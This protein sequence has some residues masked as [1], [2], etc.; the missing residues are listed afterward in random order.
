MNN[1]NFVNLDFKFIFNNVK[2]KELTNTKIGLVEGGAGLILCFSYLYKYTNNDSYLNDLL[3]LLDSIDMIEN[4]INDFSLGTGLTGLAW[5]I[6]KIGNDYIEN[7]S[8]WLLEIQPSLE[9]EY[10]R[11]IYLGNIDYFGGALGL[12]FYF[13]TTKTITSDSLS[14]CIEL[15]VSYV[16][17]L[18]DNTSVQNFDSKN[19]VNRH[20]AIINLGVP[21]GITG[22]L[23]FLLL[24]K[25]K[26][27]LKGQDA[28]VLIIK[29]ADYL[30]DKEL[31]IDGFYH[32][33]PSYCDKRNSIPYSGLSWCYGD[34]MIA[35]ALLKV[36]ILFENGLYYNHAMRV[37]NDTLLQRYL[38]DQTLVLCH[39]YTSLSHIYSKIFLLTKESQF[40]NRSEEWREKASLSFDFLYGKY[41][42][43][44]ENSGFFENPSLFYGISGYFLSELMWTKLFIDDSWLDC[45]LL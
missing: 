38:H 19:E 8:D 5:I 33:F 43:T 9:N 1:E 24:L 20:S 26:H 27:L 23:L 25:D 37:L 3:N 2:N 28:D 15:F 30:L 44:G 32:H 7:T 35:Y 4:E 13:V 45:L 40:K 16:L 29:I 39:G 21:H 18:L 12:L 31:L 41:L 36:G 10:I 42:E 6:S 11:M 17:G 34:L 22:I 14:F